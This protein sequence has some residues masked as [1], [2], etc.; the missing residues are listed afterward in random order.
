VPGPATSKDDGARKEYPELGEYTR[1]LARVSEMVADGTDA[2][3]NVEN[4][5]AE[6]AGLFNTGMASVFVYDGEGSLKHASGFGIPPHFVRELEESGGG[7]WARDLLGEGTKPYV[8][9]DAQHSP[10]VPAV[11]D[12]ACAIGVVTLVLVPLRTE[13]K[14]LGMMVLYHRNARPYTDKEQDVL[15]T[16]ASMAAVIMVRAQLSGA[17]GNNGS[18]TQLFNVLS[19]ELR[20]PLTSIMGFTQIIRKRLSASG[21]SDQRL[22]GQLDVLWAQAQR[23]NRLIDTF[24][25]I[26]RIERGE[27]QITRG[28]VE[29]TST[30]KDAAS[31]AVAEASA[32]NPINISVPDHPVWL[33]GDA[34]RLE[35]AISQLIANA[36]R[37]SPQDKPIDVTCEELDGTGQVAV[38]ITD[39]GP[40]IPPA[41]TKEIFER[42]Y[43]SG[44]LKSGGLGVGIYLSKVIVEAHGGQ[45]SI[46]SALDTGTTVTIYLPV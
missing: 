22:M 23:L 34:R 26:A 27:F 11:R 20:T 2:R 1:T 36:V 43:P 29:L 4:I 31:R 30:V 25:D 6:T 46:D 19:H 16:L 44:P 14:L 33:H 18:R 9:E 41:R 40:G 28:K 42:N 24:V 3:A 32:H 12:W 35:H 38:K 17:K 45:L 15:R 39:R 8:I 5:A 21:Y 13:G 37:Y 10:P 7:G